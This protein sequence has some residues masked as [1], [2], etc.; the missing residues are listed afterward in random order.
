MKTPALP[1]TICDILHALLLLLVVLVCCPARA[2]AQSFRLETTGNETMS[3]LLI[4]EKAGSADQFL[5][6]FKGTIQVNVSGAVESLEGVIESL[7]A[8]YGEEVK[9]SKTEFK[10]GTLV[11]C[12]EKGER[13]VIFDIHSN[14]AGRIREAGTAAEAHVASAGQ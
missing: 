2:S 8:E 4:Q 12:T 14:M 3:M 11:I 1:T 6:R 10:N 9:V 7:Q 13:H 5:L